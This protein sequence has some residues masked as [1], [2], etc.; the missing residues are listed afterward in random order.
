MSAS[1]PMRRL[2]WRLYWA[3]PWQGWTYPGLYVWA[4]G[5]N[6]RVL[7][8]WGSGWRG[9]FRCR[10]CGLTWVGAGAAPCGHTEDPTP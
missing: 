5:R 10:R 2:Y 9:V 1:S 4:F 8:L 7:P 6:I 3:G